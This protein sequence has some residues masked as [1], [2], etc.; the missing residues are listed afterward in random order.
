MIAITVRFRVLYVLLLIEI[1]SRRIVHCNVTEHPTADWTLQQFREAIPCDHSYRFS[2]H[3]RHAT[4]STEFDQAIEHLRITPIKT[5][6]RAPQTNAFCERLIGTVRRECLD[7]VIP[8]NERHLRKI[9]REW[10][11]HDKLRKAT[12]QPRPRSPRPS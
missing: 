12:F 3:D 2:I 4:F 8:F 11:A 1:G 9:L 6:I 10:V 7:Y 5:P